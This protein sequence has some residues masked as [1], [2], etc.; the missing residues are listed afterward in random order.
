M[1]SQT[2]PI[3]SLEKYKHLLKGKHSSEFGFSNG[4]LQSS[5][6]ISS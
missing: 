2:E 5:N 3:C 6:K 4:A 1:L